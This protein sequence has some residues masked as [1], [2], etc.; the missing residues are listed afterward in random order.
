MIKAIEPL[1][2]KMCTR[3]CECAETS[4]GG[5]DS[6]LEARV[7]TTFGRASSLCNLLGIARITE[8][9]RLVWAA[10]PGRIHL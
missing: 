7:Q 8:S 1:L 2:R 3:T 10:L 4:A 5:T 9:L 6:R